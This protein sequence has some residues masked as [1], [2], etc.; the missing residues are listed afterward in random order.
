M[1]KFLKV[2]D[3]EFAGEVV[4]YQT[5]NQSA[6]AAYGRHP[7]LLSAMYEWSVKANRELYN[8]LARLA[9]VV[10]DV[11][12][13][14][15]NALVIYR[16]FSQDTFQDSLNVHEN[17][18]VGD[19]GRYQTSERMMSATTD[20]DVASVF[21]DIVVKM[22]IYPDV[23]EC[24]LVTDELIYAAMKHRHIEEPKTQSEVILM[25]PIAM[26]W[27]VVKVGKN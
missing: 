5:L 21:G 19:V 11:Q 18:K 2:F 20:F 16:G 12:P 22:T 27:E 26:E 13:P 14:S 7:E 10:K 15:G 25:P 17:P 23:D 4:S 3:N 24:L 1:G 9:R 6:V 8:M